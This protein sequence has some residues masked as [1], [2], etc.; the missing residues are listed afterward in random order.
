MV[1]APEASQGG[2]LVLCEN[3]WSCKSGI[4]KEYE[5]SSRGVCGQL[6]DAQGAGVMLAQILTQLETKGFFSVANDPYLDTNESR[7]SDHS[8]SLQIVDGA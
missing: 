3:A 7:F 5:S 4:E 1:C 2:P 8:R 6:A